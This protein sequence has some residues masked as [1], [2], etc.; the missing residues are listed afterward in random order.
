MHKQL[1]WQLALLFQ[2][3]HLLEICLGLLSFDRLVPDR[4]TIPTAGVTTP[5]GKTAITL[6]QRRIYWSLKRRHTLSSTTCSHFGIRVVFPS[7]T[8]VQLKRQI[9]FWSK[10]R[11]KQCSMI[12]EIG[13]GCGA[14]YVNA[15]W[16]VDNF[17]RSARQIGA[18]ANRSIE[19]KSQKRETINGRARLE[20]K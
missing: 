17:D 14:S 6:P 5:L 3:V 8:V 10:F 4:L 1:T 2:K 18:L 15:L 16:P 20:K 11:R 19:P 12:N 7:D 13:F 9:N